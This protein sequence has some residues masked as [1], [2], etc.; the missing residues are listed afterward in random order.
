MIQFLITIGLC[1]IPYALCFGV[2]LDAWG[3][4]TMNFLLFIALIVFA[5]LGW[6]YAWQA[7]G[8]IS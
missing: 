8:R 3:K 6:Q 1:L 7:A 4:D 5:T 2:L